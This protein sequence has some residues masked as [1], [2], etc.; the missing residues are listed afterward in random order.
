[1]NKRKGSAESGGARGR[2]LRG[3]EK[4]GTADSQDRKAKRGEADHRGEAEG[5]TKGEGGAAGAAQ[6]A[7]QKR[8]KTAGRKTR[9]KGGEWATAQERGERPQGEAGGEKR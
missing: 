4:G 9:L 7:A 3:G 8:W 6:G 5:Q 2:N 1:M